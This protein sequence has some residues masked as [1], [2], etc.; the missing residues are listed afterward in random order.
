MSEL[1][2][3]SGQCLIGKA[4]DKTTLTDSYGEKLFIGDIVAIHTDVSAPSLTVICDD[5]YMG[6]YDS[7][8][9]LGIRSVDYMK[10]DS[11]WTVTKVKSYEDLVEGERWPRFG[12]RV[13]TKP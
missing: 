8:F 10:P 4:G 5:S 1:Y 7:P 11:V 6:N 2:I 9:V 3:Y 13:A 12:F